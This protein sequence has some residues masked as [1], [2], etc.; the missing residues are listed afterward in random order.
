MDLSK[1]KYLLFDIDD[2]ILSFE[3]AEHK[4]LS[5]ALLKVGVNPTNKVLS[6]YHDIN[7]SYW[8]QVEIGLI[9]RDECLIK[10]FDEFLPIYGINMDSH[11]FEDLYRSYLNKQHYLM[12]NAR[13]VLKVL[14]EKYLIYSV[15]N[16]VLNTQLVRVKAA[17]LNDLFDKMY[18][19]EAIGVNK[20]DPRFIE[21]II[22]DDKSFDK[23]KALII[24][25]SLTSDIKLGVNTNIDTCWFNF[26]NQTNN[27]DIKP[28]YE[29]HS[30]LELIK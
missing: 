1:Y 8:K 12:N 28:T 9:T 14:K 17:K 4:A 20:P 22:N 23:T 25:D 15:S 26:N 10:R 19:S 18:I 6:H 29:I 2:T 3:K 24:G 21:Y 13:K 5:L 7:I 16:G 30:L 27:S 11:E